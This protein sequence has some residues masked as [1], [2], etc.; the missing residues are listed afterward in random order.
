MVLVKRKVYNANRQELN[1]LL[2]TAQASQNELR[3]QVEQLESKRN[4]LQQDI[5]EIASGKKIVR[6]IESRITDERYVNSLGIISW[7]RKDF[8]ELDYL[9]KQQ[10]DALKRTELKRTEVE[11]V[12]RIDRIILYIDD[13]D[14]CNEEI[15]VRVLEAIHLLLA[16]PLFV[17]KG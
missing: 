8:E 15:V 4:Q 2:E 16:F 11:N 7:I 10:Y 13:L 14:R 6:F 9:L 1:H 5:D 17:G 3:Q 12:F